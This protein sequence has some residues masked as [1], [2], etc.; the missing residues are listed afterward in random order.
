MSERNEKAQALLAELTEQVETL[1]TSEGWTAWLETA[2]RFH[3]YSVGNQLLI[4]MQREDA[5]YVAG[6]KTWQALGR[7]VRKGER[8]IRILAPCTRKVHDDEDDT[9]RVVV[10]GFRPV[11]VFDI[12]QTDGDALPA[13]PVRQYAQDRQATIGSYKLVVEV[14]DRLGYA[15]DLEPAPGPAGPFGWFDR[16][17]STVHV[18]EDSDGAMAKTALHEL[19]HAL[20]PHLGDD[21]KANELTAESACYVI[22]QLC[23]ID[24]TAPSVTYLAS[25]GL[26]GPAA[27]A[28]ANRVLAVV[29]RITHALTTA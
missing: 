28:I 18:C 19:A 14:A 25:W 12:A 2:A 27:Q 23:G 22:G 16:T 21:R 4:A 8:G 20:D 11:A 24:T 15:I 1:R 5:T 29:D 9:E 17:T 13:D 10:A 7:Q 3:R 26:D 6:F